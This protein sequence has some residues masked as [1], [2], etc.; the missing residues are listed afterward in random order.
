MAEI[1]PLVTSMSLLQGQRIKFLFSP[2]PSTVGRSCASRVAIVFNGL[3]NDLNTKESCMFLKPASLNWALKHVRKEGDTD[4]FPMPF[5]FEIIKKYCTT[6]RVELKAK[7]I[8]TCDWRG[9]RRLMV[10]KSEFAFRAV[11]QLDPEDSILFAAIIREIGEKIEKGRSEPAK[12]SVFSYRYDP[13]A[14]GRLYAANTGW[15]QFWKT[16]SAHCD[17]F[18]FV[19]TTDISDWYNQIYHHTIENQLDTLG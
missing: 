3:M 16:S 2:T 18:P 10:P 15:E 9:P 6:V 12:N 4:L 7:E 19:L 14:D 1:S 13:D 5:E 8:N 17:D 11:C